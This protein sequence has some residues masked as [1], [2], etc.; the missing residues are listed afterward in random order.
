MGA[1]RVKWLAN[2]ATGLCRCGRERL[3]GR[4]SCAICTAK[5]LAK[6]RLQTERRRTLGLCHSCGVIRDGKGVRCVE[7]SAAHAATSQ[8]IKSEVIDAYGGKCGCCGEAERAFLTID[9]SND[10]GASHRKLIGGG[11][12]KMYRWLKKHG[13]PQEGFAL[14]CFNCNL[15]RRV[16]GGVCPHQQLA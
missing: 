4:K 14:M 13:F 9:H 16:N 12:D 15:G 5:S 1:S 7:C 6:S 3:P 11:G 2:S 8:R 10:D